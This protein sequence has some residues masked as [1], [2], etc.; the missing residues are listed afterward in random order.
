MPFPCPRG[1]SGVCGDPDASNIAALAWDGEVS[2]LAGRLLRE[3]IAIADI[4]AAE[5]TSAR[6]SEAISIAFGFALAGSPVDFTEGARALAKVAPYGKWLY[7][8]CKPCGD[9]VKVP[10][11]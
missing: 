3:L 7:I 9:F 1:D 5:P 11:P 6:E 8:E 10:V 2:V 4:S